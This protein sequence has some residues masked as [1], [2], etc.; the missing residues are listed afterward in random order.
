MPRFFAVRRKKK[1]SYRKKYA[2]KR[3]AYRKKS[4]PFSYAK[5]IDFWEDWKDLLNKDYR[6][7]GKPKRS[8]VPSETRKQNSFNQ[9]RYVLPNVADF[10]RKFSV[11]RSEKPHNLG[12]EKTAWGGL[13]PRYDSSLTSDQYNEYIRDIGSKGMTKSGKVNYS[14]LVRPEEYRGSVRAKKI[15]PWSRDD[16]YQMTRD[17]AD[18]QAFQAARDQIIK[19]TKQQLENYVIPASYRAA[20]QLF[21]N[22]YG[23]PFNVAVN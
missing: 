23:Q 6:S 10:E 2:P 19:S 22:R 12:F 13:K 21:M 7:S 1:K 5:A 8:Y 11:N 3:N 18:S 15:N 16:I 20:K 14:Y 9:R 4:L 17:L